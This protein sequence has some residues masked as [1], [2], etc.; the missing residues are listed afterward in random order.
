MPSQTLLQCLTAAKARRRPVL[1]GENAAAGLQGTVEEELAIPAAVDG[2]L[3]RPQLPSK[4]AELVVRAAAVYLSAGSVRLRRAA[5]A[6]IREACK[7]RA[8]VRSSNANLV[9]R[10]PK[11]RRV[12]HEACAVE[13]AQPNAELANH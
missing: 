2:D 12:C 7:T 6:V 10:C 5:T 13:V 4:R 3:G 1:S 11:S 8:E 9:G